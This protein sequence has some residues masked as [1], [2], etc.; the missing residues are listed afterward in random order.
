MGG[1]DCEYPEVGGGQQLEQLPLVAVHGGGLQLLHHLEGKERED[2]DGCGCFK[3][4]GSR[5]A[6]WGLGV[7]TRPQT[8]RPSQPLRQHQEAIRPS[9]TP[10]LM[11][12][13][14][15]CWGS[16]GLTG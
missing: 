9:A 4:A 11:L 10:G 12:P 8:Q 14:K 16:E 15:S 13:G 7:E 6:G 3:P 2:T 5:R 1:R